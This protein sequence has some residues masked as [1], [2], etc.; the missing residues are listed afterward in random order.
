M[1]PPSV[2][3]IVDF[4]GLLAGT[5]RLDSGSIGSDQVHPGW[6]GPVLTCGWY[7]ADF[8]P[9]IDDTWLRGRLFPLAWLLT[10]LRLGSELAL[11]KAQLKAAGN[12]NCVYLISGWPRDDAGLDRHCHG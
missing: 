6:A 11:V 10:L 3:A 8:C 12:G 9:R 7:D 1:E 2:S 4:E 5:I